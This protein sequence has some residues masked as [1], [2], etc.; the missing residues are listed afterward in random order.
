[1]REDN[2]S[3]E[4]PAR[5]AAAGGCRDPGRRRPASLCRMARKTAGILHSAPG[6]CELQKIALA[7]PKT[8]LSVAAGSGGYDARE[9][10]KG[11]GI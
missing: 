11:H 3:R 4:I 1:M 8:R 10:E 9:P 5:P 6:I 7:T 2:R